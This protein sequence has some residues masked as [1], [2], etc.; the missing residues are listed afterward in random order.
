MSPIL[1]V[2]EGR[3]AAKDLTLPENISEVAALSGMPAEHAKRTV[4][5]APRLLKSQ[6][7]GN[8]YSHLWELSWKNGDRWTNPLMGWTS[9]ADPQHAVRVSAC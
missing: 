9:G 4:V 7:V 1:G 5:I 6:Q 2:V 8:K 3:A